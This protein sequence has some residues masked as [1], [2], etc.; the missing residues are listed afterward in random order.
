M[1]TGENMQQLTWMLPMK[2]VTIEADAGVSIRFNW[3]GTHNLYKMKSKQE[4]D[5][6]IF[7]GATYMGNRS[8]IIVKFE[9]GTD[10]YACKVAKHCRKGQKIAI[11]ESRAPVVPQPE[12]PTTPVYPNAVKVAGL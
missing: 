6:C 7:V 4:F 9:G 12:I 8:P 3:N 2:S 5:K 10:Y 1:G 11:T